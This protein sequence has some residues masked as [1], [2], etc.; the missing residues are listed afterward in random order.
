MP[1]YCTKCGRQNDDQA[2]YCVACGTPLL[3][4]PAASRVWDA[5]PQTAYRT[6]H[7]EM[8][9]GEHQHILT[10]IV[11]KD[12]MGVVVFTAKRPSLIHENFDILDV[13]GQTQGHVSR[14]MHLNGSSF[15]IS[16]ASQNVVN[17]VQIRSHR[18]GV[19]PTCWLE[20]DKGGK[21][22]TL[23]F[24]GF[25]SFDLL[26]P[27]GSKIL[28]ASKASQGGGVMQELRS[29][30]A[31]RFSIQVFD[32]NFSDLQLAGTFAAID[33]AVMA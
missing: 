11:F 15:E 32:Q 12:D 29:L 21:E 5:V 19:P 23:E 22:A 3:Q 31:R 13:G 30:T 18:R 33:T 2:A 26:K 16:D 24:E 4:E 6:L 8:T 28:S 14:T 7:A 9:A 1:R 27:D 25:A 10:N 20:D 17:V